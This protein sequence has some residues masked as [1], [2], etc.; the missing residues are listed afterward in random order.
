MSDST[1]YLNLVRGSRLKNYMGLVTPEP[2]K[3]GPGYLYVEIPAIDFIVSEG[4]TT[5]LKRN[6]RAYVVP[7]CTIDPK[8]DAVIE[9]EPTIAL[10]VNAIVQAS[11]KVHPKTGKMVPG[12]WITPHRDLNI[13]DL[14]YA[15]RLYMYR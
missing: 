6:Q 9:V 3:Y 15:V 12:F 10:S 4:S 2:Y 14:D 7:D 5:T 8:A 11:Y 13:A 1:T